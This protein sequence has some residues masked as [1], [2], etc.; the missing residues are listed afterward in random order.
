MG[1]RYIS[2]SDFL[3]TNLI[4]FVRFIIIIGM[5]F[6]CNSTVCAVVLFHVVFELR[7]GISS[8]VCWHV[9]DI[10]KC[11]WWLADQDYTNERLEEVNGPLY[12]K[13][14]DR[15]NGTQNCGFFKGKKRERD[16]RG[17]DPAKLH[18]DSL[19]N[20]DDSEPG[21]FNLDDMESKIAKI[22]ERWTCKC[23]SSR[24]AITSY[25]T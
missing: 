23:R 22:T 5:N 14:E 2:S 3:C 17:I 18:R 12:N 9:F 8:F 11:L 4:P 20:I 7:A 13:A 24:G 15:L 6:R 21:S 16:E 1:L 25:G 10:D 19:H